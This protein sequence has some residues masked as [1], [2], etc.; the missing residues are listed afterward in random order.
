VLQ[1]LVLMGIFGEFA[2]IK[3]TGL[4]VLNSCVFEKY[5]FA[6]QFVSFRRHCHCHFVIVC[7][8]MVIFFFLETL[9][10]WWHLFGF[11]LN[12]NLLSF[13]ASNSRSKLQVL[14]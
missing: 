3:Y 2:K 9:E 13:F 4:G 1:V 14:F 11:R 12:F 7:K 6:L 8:E 5:L 10:K